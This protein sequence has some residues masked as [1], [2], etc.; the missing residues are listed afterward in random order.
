MIAEDIAGN[1]INN[2]ASNISGVKNNPRAKDRSDYFDR[3]VPFRAVG[4]CSPTVQT[5]VTLALPNRRTK[6]GTAA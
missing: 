2:E 6:N 4:E 5:T 1:K 3:R